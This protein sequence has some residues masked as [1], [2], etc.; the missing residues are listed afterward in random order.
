MLLRPPALQAALTAR[1]ICLHFCSPWLRMLDWQESA[2]LD[3]SENMLGH[4]ASGG[5][6]AA[7]H[8][9]A[10]VPQAANILHSCVAGEDGVHLRTSNISTWRPEVPTTRRCPAADIVYALPGSGTAATNA[11]PAYQRKY[12]VMITEAPSHC[13]VP[14]EL[15]VTHDAGLVAWRVCIWTA[16]SARRRLVAARKGQAA[17]AGMT[18]TLSTTAYGKGA[19]RR[20]GAGPTA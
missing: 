20:R 14:H 15:C 19:S 4:D 11:W 8:G 16:I 12:T 5:V 9:L 1:R 10:L 13:I 6:W 3:G 18:R 17:A 7:A 2:G